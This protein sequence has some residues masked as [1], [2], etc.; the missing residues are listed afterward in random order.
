MKGIKRLEGLMGTP[1][2]EWN[3]APNDPT[4]VAKA[5]PCI[6]SHEEWGTIIDIGGNPVRVDFA[7]LCRRE[8]FVTVDNT[9]ITVDSE[10]LTADDL[11]PLPNSG[12]LMSYRGRPYKMVTK[13]LSPD[14]SHVIF[15]FED[16]NS[17]M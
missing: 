7:V 16:P 3:A 6:P 15:L 8:L 17:G 9:E 4:A 14:G 2:I 1:T 11:T 13:S 10:L 12:E 5:L